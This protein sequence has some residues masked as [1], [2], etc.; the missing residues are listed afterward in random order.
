MVLLRQQANTAHDTRGLLSKWLAVVFRNIYRSVFVYTSTLYQIRTTRFVVINIFEYPSSFEYERVKWFK[1]M[2][3]GRPCTV[4][5]DTL[6][7]QYE[8]VKNVIGPWWM[9][10]ENFSKNVTENVMKYF[11]CYLNIMNVVGSTDWVSVHCFGTHFS[12]IPVISL[13]IFNMKHF[14]PAD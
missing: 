6:Y 10:V 11:Q 7:L 8:N 2:L 14:L 9:L 4:P 1:I 3:L 12:I 5:R 13:S